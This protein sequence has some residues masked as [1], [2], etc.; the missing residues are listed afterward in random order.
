MLA[1]SMHLAI[2]PRPGATVKYCEMS[3]T[4]WKLPF[5]FNMSTGVRNGDWYE[6]SHRPFWILVYPLLN[7]FD[8][9]L[10]D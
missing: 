9:D 1:D 10:C 7:G 5:E 3:V 2:R 4:L 6:W 8:S